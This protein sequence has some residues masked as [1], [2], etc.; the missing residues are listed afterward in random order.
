MNRDPV[1]E[2]YVD[3]ERSN[4]VAEHAGKDHYFCSEACQRAFASDPEKFLSEGTGG[5]AHGTQMGSMGGCCGGGSGGG[6]RG[7]L[8]TAIMLILILLLLFR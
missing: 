6:R 2:M 5:Q 8:N 7:Y 3:P 1:C 4:W